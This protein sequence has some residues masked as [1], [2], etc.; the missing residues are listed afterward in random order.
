[1]NAKEKIQVEDLIQEVKVLKTH[2]SKRLVKMEGHLYDDKDTNQEGLIH[3]QQILES[4]LDEVLWEIKTAKKLFALISG[5]VA[6]AVTLIM[7]WVS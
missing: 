4:K 5:A 6:A 3:K 7:K 2:L 1:M